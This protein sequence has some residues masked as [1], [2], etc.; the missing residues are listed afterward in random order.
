MRSV[1]VIFLTLSSAIAAL[2]P[3]AEAQMRRGC[4]E[5]SAVREQMRAMFQEEVTALAM[6]GNGNLLILFQTDMSKVERGHPNAWTLYSATPNGVACMVAS[7]FNWETMTVS[8][9]ET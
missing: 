2:A 5:L 9:P 3:P 6:Q 1:A 7:G 8:G 4:S